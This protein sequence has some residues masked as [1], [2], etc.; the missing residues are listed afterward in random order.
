[1]MAVR[2]QSH[3]NKLHQTAIPPATTLLGALSAS[4]GL[5]TT[6]VPF[7]VLNASDEIDLSHGGEL[8]AKGF[9]F[10]ADV[11]QFH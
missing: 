2:S 9:C 5:I 4:V 7:C 11:C 3:A 10:V 6:G 1:M 8:D